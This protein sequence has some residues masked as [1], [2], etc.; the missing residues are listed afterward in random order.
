[1]MSSFGSL[2]DYI[3]INICGQAGLGI[4]VATLRSSSG[5]LGIYPRLNNSVGQAPRFTK[6]LSLLN[7]PR[8]GGDVRLILKSTFYSFKLQQLRSESMA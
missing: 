5:S 4:F 6:V 3:I 2:P 1:M 7:S 8:P